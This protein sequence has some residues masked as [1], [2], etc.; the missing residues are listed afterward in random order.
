MV[1]LLPTLLSALRSRSDLVVET[2]VLRQQLATLASRQHPDIRPADRDFWSLLRR[3]WTG[4]A[5]SLA[6][7]EA[8]CRSHDGNCVAVT[9]R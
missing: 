6:T 1:A 4:W 7:V 8:S 5:A 3:G 9:R 2:L